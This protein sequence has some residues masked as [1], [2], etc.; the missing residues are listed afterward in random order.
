MIQYGVL[1]LAAE[2]N[3]ELIRN[4]LWRDA[5]ERI[6]IN[7]EKDYNKKHAFDEAYNKRIKLY[8]VIVFGSL[9]LHFHCPTVGALNAESP[10]RTF[11]TFQKSNL[12]TK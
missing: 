1:R 7:F 10:R 12:V 5:A 8:I 9:P 3:F 2:T 11:P 4:F 6:F